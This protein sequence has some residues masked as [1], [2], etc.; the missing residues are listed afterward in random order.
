MRKNVERM[1]ALAA[2]CMLTSLSACRREAPA[3]PSQAG[4]SPIELTAGIAGESAAV[5][6]AV[7]TTDSPYGTPAQGLRQ[8]TSLYMV[9]KSEKDDNDALYTRTIGF[10][11]ES[12]V[13]TSN[14]VKFASDYG[15]FWEDSYSRNSQLSVYAACVP[16]YYLAASVS[17]GAT[18]SGAEDSSIWRIGGH[19]DYDNRW[20]P[21][22]DATDI[23]WPLRD[24]TAG[25]QADDFV[26]AQD[27]C[28]SNNV[29]ALAGENRV[30]FDES[31]KKFGSG[32]LVF[33]HALTKVTFRIRKGEGFQA[34][35]KFAFSN[36]NE[37]VVLRN[38]NLRGTFD[39]R[40]G[41]FDGTS[42]G[43]GDLT[44]FKNQGGN[45][46]FA[47]I[48][49][50]LLVP[51][52]DL[53]DDTT[54][55]VYFTIDYNLYHLSKKTL[56]NALAGKTFG[57]SGTPAL[58]GTRMRPGVHYIFDMTVGKKK[59][60]SFTASVMEWEE[61][62]AAETKPSNARIVVSLMDNGTHK[63]GTADFDLYRCADISPVIDDNYEGFD[64]TAGYEGPATLEETT[65]G[66]YAAKDWYW[67]DN[68]TFYHF[69]T[70]MPRDHEVKADAT[71]GDY[72]TLTG[73][74]V[75]TDVCWGAPYDATSHDIYKAIGPTQSTIHLEMKHMMSE[76]TIHLTSSD[77][78]DQVYVTN[79][80]MELSKICPNG[81]VRMG[82]GTVTPTGTPGTV[83]NNTQVPWTHGFV[84]QE[85]EG[86]VLTITTGDGNQYLV[87]MKDV[88]ET[89]GSEKITRW[90]PNHKYSY[91]FKLTKT[92]ISKITATLADWEEVT[93]GDDNVK[94]Q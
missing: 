45:D 6:K 50:A 82:D 76:V 68:K 18:V 36:P 29:S 81:I 49:D 74:D 46:T 8:G 13:A 44:E 93:A 37:N 26:A 5:T 60:D 17:D 28:F 33:Y 39:L 91:T 57:V 59:M 24:D 4:K 86:V 48:L 47:H 34:G 55:Q 75:Y 65:A 79:A 42:V 1:T 41:E 11:Q 3:G 23:E 78:L 63:T 16:G 32:H 67:P 12:P 27:L 61:V 73:D 40:E 21:G 83:S 53:N 56:L 89:G 2:L 70:V 30:T 58:D 94:I 35:D 64:W 22:S 20:L 80:T 85:L 66:I 14:T 51:G 84:P 52:T 31:L 7:V 9:M 25:H 72:F 88:L 92:G 69:R 10:A 87:D 90:E 54:D 77:G 19:S 38:V 43:I 62:T 71:D 15:R